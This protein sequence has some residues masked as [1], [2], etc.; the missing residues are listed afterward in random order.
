MTVYDFMS[1]LDKLLGEKKIAHWYDSR[2]K[3]K[4]KK[5]RPVRT[6]LYSTVPELSYR[7]IKKGTSTG[8]KLVSWKMEL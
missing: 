2:N 4:P 6:S 7:L 3:T 5:I 1:T 8:L